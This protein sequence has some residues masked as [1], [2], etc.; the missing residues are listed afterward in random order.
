MV[1]KELSREVLYLGTSLWGP[2]RLGISPLIKKRLMKEGE[3]SK[4]DYYDAKRCQDKDSWWK[5]NK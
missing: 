4:F 3:I 5:I 2:R 1:E